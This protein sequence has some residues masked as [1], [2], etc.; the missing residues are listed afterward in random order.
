VFVDDEPSIV[1]TWGLILKASGYEVVCCGDA[2][3]ALRAIAGGCDLVITDYHMPGMNGVELIRA[4]RARCEAG[5][6]LLTANATPEV[7]TAALEAGAL[8][9]VHKPVGPQQLLQQVAILCAGL[10]RQRKSPP[11]RAM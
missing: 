11:R 1:K 8:C 2:A 6:V 4:A 5:F 9:V 3:T 10:M 7:A